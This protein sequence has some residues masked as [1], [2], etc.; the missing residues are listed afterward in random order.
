MYAYIN[1]EIYFV[2]FLGEIFEL[3]NRLRAVAGIQRMEEFLRIA[4]ISGHFQPFI[5]V[6]PG[7]GGRS[8]PTLPM[9]R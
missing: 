6:I 1:A 2:L 3:K 4:N 5:A 8:C 7:R 9:D